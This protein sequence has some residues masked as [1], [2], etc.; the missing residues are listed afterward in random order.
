MTKAE[1]FSRQDH[2]LRVISGSCFKMSWVSLMNSMSCEAPG[3]SG[4]LQSREETRKRLSGEPVEGL[5]EAL[6]IS[7]KAPLCPAT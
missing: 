4:G 2:A 5:C 7:N 6:Q 1:A 3:G